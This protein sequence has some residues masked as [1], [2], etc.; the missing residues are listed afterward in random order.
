MEAMKSLTVLLSTALFISRLVAEQTI[1]EFEH[2]SVDQGLSQS[3]VMAILQDSRGFMWF[4]TQDGL[5]KY[6]GIDFQTYRKTPSGPT[7]LRTSFIQHIYEDRFGKLWIATDGAGFQEFDPVTGHTTDYRIQTPNNEWK[8]YEVRKFDEDLQGRLW[9]ASRGNLLLFDRSAREFSYFGNDKEA[10]N[11]VNTFTIDRS[12]NIW[13][14]LHK[15]GLHTFDPLRK[16]FDPVDVRIDGRKLQGGSISTMYEDMSGDL[17]FV[18]R[19]FGLVRLKTAENKFALYEVA[20][21]NP[22]CLSTGEIYSI[23]EDD[24]KNLWLG[25]IG[26]GINIFDRKTETFA[27][28]VHDPYQPGSLSNNVVQSIYKDLA[29]CMW[30]GLSGGG[31]NKYNPRRRKFTQYKNSIQNPEALQGSLVWA[32]FEDRRGR[33]LIGTVDGGLNILDRETGVFEVFKHK[34]DDPSSI[35]SDFVWSICEDNSGDIWIGTNHGG[36]NRFNPKN[37]SFKRYWGSPKQ[38][39]GMPGNSVRTLLVDS[40]N[41]LWFGGGGLH[42]LNPETEEF[43]HY[44]HDPADAGSISSNG[45]SSIFQARNGVLWVGSFSSGLN[46][47]DA[48]K[49]RFERYCRGCPD[50]GLTSNYVIAINDDSQ[51]NIWIGTYNGLNKL[52]PITGEIT[53]YTTEQGLPNDVIYGVLTDREDRIWVSTNKGLSRYDQKTKKFRNYA[54][55]DGLQSLEFNSG[56][57]YKNKRGE[58]FFGGVKGFNV[59]HP[60]S[61]RDNPVPP[62]VVITGLKKFDQALALTSNPRTPIEFRHD[63]NFIQFEFVAL[64]YTNPVKNKYAYKLAGL[65]DDW[66][67]CNTQRH[68]TFTNLHPGNYVFH[69]KGANNDGVWNESGA[70]LPF[71]VNPP[72]WRAWWFQLVAVLLSLALLM[73]FV[74]QVRERLRAKAELNKK[75]SELKLK[76][77]RAQMNPHFIFNTINSIQ[78]YISSDAQKLAFQYLSKFARLMRMV[79]DNSEKASQTIGE[80]LEALRLYLE[81]ESLRFEGKFSY[82]IDVSPEIDLLHDEIPTMLIQPFVENAIQ[83]GLS[84]S[85]KKGALNIKLD[86]QNRTLICMIEDNGIGI[87]K[88]LELKEQENGNSFHKSAGIKVSQERLETLNALRKKGKAIEIV[89]LCRENGQ[90]GCRKG[91]RVKIAIPMYDS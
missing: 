57:F 44:L 19:P 11:S 31:V 78:Y 42:S 33:T 80:E 38:Y 72:F 84:R 5:N 39:E 61:V 3:S 70:S 71:V 30:V 75:I 49:Q 17:W 91:T 35:G 88:S 10:G 27:K 58:M 63:D 14:S 79:L 41:L 69:V 21:D 46:R 6:D 60:D 26:D 73:L 62:S 16:K 53:N 4:G 59:F 68:A 87:E 54:L 43:S 9:L 77:L 23:A 74:R 66:I 89:D 12:D 82:T 65:H 86:L 40:N 52:D 7:V 56:A 37:K 1:I 83:H 51:G 15:K 76:A 48:E 45:V 36:L 13:V 18:W 50:D 64:D 22:K 2:I 47:F 34:P 24:H 55:E 28:I 20:P 67:Y 8:G 81:L 90:N 85:L 25:S 29:G 32:L